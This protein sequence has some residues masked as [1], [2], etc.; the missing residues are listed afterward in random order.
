MTLKNI[1]SKPQAYEVTR[2]TQGSN[3]LRVD[4]INRQTKE[5]FSKW[6]SKS[7][8]NIL[9]RDWGRNLSIDF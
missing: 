4:A 6:V 8:F 2:V 3:K 1:I 9:C 5:R 7:Y